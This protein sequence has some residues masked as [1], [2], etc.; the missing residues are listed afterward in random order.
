MN[1]I[2]TAIADVCVFEPRVFEDTRGY[3]FESFN[4]QVF[5]AAI[6]R[7]VSFVQDNQSH[8]V[9]GVLRGLHY[10]LNPHA[11][12]KL[13]RVLSGE[14]YDVAIDLR[15]DSPTFGQWVAEILSDKN[16]RQL[17]IPEG[18]A[19]GFVV[20]SETAD[21]LYKT[22]DY[23]DKTSERSIIWNDPHLNIDWPIQAQHLVFSEKDLQAGSFSQADL[24][25]N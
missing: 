23:W 17:W 19:H 15:R 6:G 3:F 12:G 7:S 22:T 21:V 24:F 13:V 8:S 11:Q 4:H 2:R 5:E 10:Q 14:I 20:L 18:F 25:N 16:R 1:C 9:H